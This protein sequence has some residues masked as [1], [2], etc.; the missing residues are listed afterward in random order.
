MIKIY[1]NQACNLQ[2]ETLLLFSSS[3]FAKRSK[4]L[5]QSH[6]LSPFCQFEICN[7]N[8]SLF[9]YIAATMFEISQQFL[10]L[11]P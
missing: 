4:N 10:F 6:F 7:Q 11:H 8:S 5:L 3:Y 2:F 9:T 1:I